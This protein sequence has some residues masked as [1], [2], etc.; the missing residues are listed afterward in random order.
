LSL[1]P[2]IDPDAPRLRHTNDSKLKFMLTEG[3]FGGNDSAKSP[4]RKL[5]MK[6]FWSRANVCLKRFKC[7]SGAMHLAE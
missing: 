3:G 5:W 4:R 1:A 7:P 2:A 6:A